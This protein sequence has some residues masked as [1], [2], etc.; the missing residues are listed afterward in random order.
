MRKIPFAEKIDTSPVPSPI[1]KALHLTDNGIVFSF[2]ALDRTEYFNLD[3]TCQN[4]ASDML[5]MM[6]Q[7]SKLTVKQLTSGQFRTFRLH[8]LNGAPCPSQLPTGVDLKDMHQL[9]I[10]RS[11]G[12]I[13]GVLIGSCFYVIWLDPL[14]NM[15]PDKRFGGLRKVIP[16]STCCSDCD[17]EI[18]KLQE[19]LQ[20][21]IND[22]KTWEEMALEY[23]K[24]L[25]TCNLYRK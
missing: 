16:P 21:A 18:F 6:K 23:E 11:K 14:H 15:Y 20:N 9:R 22:A 12:G 8:A 13:H 19:K 17:E 2:E 4:W 10:M 3:G 25:N 5:E 1:F 24:K 7:V